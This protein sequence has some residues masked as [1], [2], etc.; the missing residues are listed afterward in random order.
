MLGLP[1]MLSDEDI[2]QELP[3][4]VDDEFISENGVQPLPYKHFSLMS[5]ANAHTKLVFIL[6]KV[7]RLIYP[8]KGVKRA[9]E[10][11]PGDGYLISHS[12]IR[13]IERDLQSWMDK[14][15][16]ELRPT[17]QAA[18]DLARH[19]SSISSFPRSLF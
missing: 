5:A 9:V 3:I 4:E 2:D 10:I 14:L 1:N 8:I 12:R 18:G 6:Q 17:D 11:H 7:V 16:M 13:N 19:V 15:P